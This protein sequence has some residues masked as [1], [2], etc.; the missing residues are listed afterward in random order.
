VFAGRRCDRLSVCDE[1]GGGVGEVLS[2]S[3]VTTGSLSLSDDDGALGGISIV[4]STKDFSRLQRSSS[5]FASSS[6]KKL[7]FEL[8]TN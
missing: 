4:V 5:A 8:L 6:L 7:S 2:A 3:V 1:G